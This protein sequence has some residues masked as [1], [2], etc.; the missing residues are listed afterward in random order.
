MGLFSKDITSMD[1]L[2]LHMLQGLYYAEHQIVRSLPKLIETAT[3]ADLKAGLS[4][5]LEESYG[6]IERLET[7]FGLIGEAV[8]GTE[9]PAIDGILADADAV[10]SDAAPPVLDAAIA[11][12]AQAV[13]HYEITRY[14]TLIAWSRELDRSQAAE[15]LSAT[16]AEEYA[17]DDKLT[18]IA[19]A[20]LNRV[21]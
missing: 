6:H 16:L 4:G 19:E 14:G 12:A 11:A 9:C 5:H 1:D 7:V 20:R 15:V 21:I 8:E 17:A 18:Q 10:T 13:E 3:D 2:Y